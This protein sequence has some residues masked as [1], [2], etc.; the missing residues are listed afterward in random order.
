[1]SEK[2]AGADNSSGRNTRRE[3]ARLCR[4]YLDALRANDVAGGYRVA[5]RALADGMSLATLYQ[6]VIRPAMHELGRLWEKGA[7]TIADEHL[8]TALTHQVLGALRPP[9]FVAHAVEA[10][11]ARPRAMLAAVQGE[12]HA[13]ALRMAADLLE[14][15]GYG[16]IYLGADVPTEALLQAVDSLSPDLLGLSAT[17]PESAPRLEDAVAGVRR[18]NPLLNVIVGGQAIASSPVGEATLVDD[19]EQLGE[20]VRAL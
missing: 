12:Q 2:S 11:S 17:M 3:G 15:A 6:S 13:L 18:T 16:T 10:D 19:F 14:E 5:S 8:A 20:Q 7:I 9:P 4:T 1:V